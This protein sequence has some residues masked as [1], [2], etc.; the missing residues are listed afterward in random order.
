MTIPKNREFAFRDPLPF[1]FVNRLGERLGPL[2]NVSVRIASQTAVEVPAGPGERAAV[3]SI[4]GQWRFAEAPVM[5]SHP[6]GAD[7]TY[8]VWLVANDRQI[9]PTPSPSQDT[10][11]YS[12]SARITPSG[13]PPAMSATTAIRR[14]THT[15]DW[16]AGKITAVRS[17]SP[18]SASELDDAAI[19]SRHL[20]TDLVLPGA[21][22]A[23]TAAPGTDSTQLATTAFVI[24]STPAGVAYLAATQTFTGVNTFPG[25]TLAPHSTAAGGIAFGVDAS[26][27]RSAAATLRTAGA[28]I[29]D[30]A[31]SAASPPAADSSTRVATTEWTRAVTNDL[32]TLIWTGGL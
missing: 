31:L 15:L 27:Y 24:A 1:W 18:T 14:R 19:R 16:A 7:G 23:T 6:G 10:T 12:F 22:S 21:P 11:D 32:E 20:G 25:L 2:S 30:G 28:L 29:V 3:V 8:D 17:L 5:V 13:S 4:E 26:L 9:A